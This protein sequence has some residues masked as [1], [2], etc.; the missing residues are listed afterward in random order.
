MTH[1]SAGRLVDIEPLLDRLAHD[2]SPDVRRILTDGLPSLIRMLSQ[3]ER[4]QLIGEWSTSDDQSRRMAIAYAFASPT[5]F[6][7]GEAAAIQHL[8]SDS[9]Q[10]VREAARDAI[11]MRRAQ[12]ERHGED[13]GEPLA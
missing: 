2:A 9:S 6:T 1:K 13:D 4:T 5:T 8:L 7:L 3:L 12:E 11:E 10:R